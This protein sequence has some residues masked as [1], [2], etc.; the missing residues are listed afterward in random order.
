MGDSSF[1]LYLTYSNE[2]VGHNQACSRNKESF[3]FLLTFTPTS[4]MFELFNEKLI[5]REG[6]KIMSN[7]NTLQKVTSDVFPARTSKNKQLAITKVTSPD[8]RSY[9]IVTPTTIA[10]A[11]MGYVI[12]RVVEKEYSWC[13][14]PSVF[15]VSQDKTYNSI[16]EDSAGV[17]FI[18]GVS[19]TFTDFIDGLD[20]PYQICSGELPYSTCD[21]DISPVINTIGQQVEEDILSKFSEDERDKALE[22]LPKAYS[23]LFK[24]SPLW[25]KSIQNNMASF[26]KK[27]KKPLVNKITSFRKTDEEKKQSQQRTDA[28]DS[29]V[30]RFLRDS[31]QIIDGTMRMS[32]DGDMMLMANSDISAYLIQYLQSQGSVV[33]SQ[34]YYGPDEKKM[35]QSG[36]MILPTLGKHKDKDDVKLPDNFISNPLLM[37]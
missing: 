29:Q 14:N 17:K 35:Y 34:D 13:H 33:S 26:V 11:S 37:M 16:D 30:D 3:S 27:D 15:N 25:L 32:S 31:A 8:K 21:V 7:K 12:D 2:D 22:T 10:R 36:D 6:V 24:I 18:N 5:Y 20:Q 9:V 1:E 4:A 19:K 23:A 28:I